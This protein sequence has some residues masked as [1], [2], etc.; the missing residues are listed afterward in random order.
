LLPVALFANPM[1]M[2]M[3]AVFANR[4]PGGSSEDRAQHDDLEEISDRVP[5]A[6]R[7]TVV[8]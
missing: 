7:A 3:L 4:L 1:T 6:P 5:H 8:E 2:F